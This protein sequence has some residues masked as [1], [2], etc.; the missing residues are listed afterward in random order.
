VTATLRITRGRCDAFVAIEWNN[1]GC[2]PS[3]G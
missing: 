1:H 2:H 3:G